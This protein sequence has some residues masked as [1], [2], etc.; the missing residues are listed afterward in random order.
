VLAQPSELA[1]SRWTSTTACQ[2]ARWAVVGVVDE[3]IQSAEPLDRLADD[4]RTVACARH[5]GSHPMAPSTQRLNRRDRLGACR[6]IAIGDGD[7]CTLACKR[8]RAGPADAERS[9][10]GNDH[11]VVNGP[12]APGRS[13]MVEQQR[14]L[15]GLV[16]WRRRPEG[17]H[18]ARARCLC[19]AARRLP[20]S[21]T[22][23]EGALA[24]GT[25][26]VATQTVAA[27]E[28]WMGLTGVAGRRW[29]TMPFCMPSRPVHGR[30]PHSTTAITSV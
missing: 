25:K 8:E 12:I 27:T 5:V 11:L 30:T 18:G 22:S 19:D 23:A 26:T 2:F 17:S 28:S 16:W 24:R 13:C 1:R 21:N 6:G 15:S 10:R 9:T 20:I 3:H 7:V 4:P 14:I 29:T